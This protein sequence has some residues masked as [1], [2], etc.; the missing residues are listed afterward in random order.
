MNSLSSLW[1]ISV[2]D[3]S[4]LSD[5]QAKDLGVI[6]D[7]FLLYFSSSLLANFAVS[8]YKTYPEFNCFSLPPPPICSEPSVTAIFFLD[9]AS[10]LDYCNNL[11]DLP[12]STLSA[13]S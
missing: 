1:I 4:I 5:V 11:A 13:N 9:Y 2:D 8:I 7:S 3:N 12:V 10:L 6:L